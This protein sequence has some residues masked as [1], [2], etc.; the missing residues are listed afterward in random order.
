[1]LTKKTVASSLSSRSQISDFKSAYFKR[2]LNFPIFL[3]MRKKIANIQ[4]PYF[5]NFKYVPPI[6]MT[7]LFYSVLSLSLQITVSFITRPGKKWIQDNLWYI[8]TLSLLAYNNLV[9]VFETF[10]GYS[11][12]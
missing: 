9:S 5:R 3:K 4:D 12:F 7:V 6:L 11:A 2:R 8:V 1:M 10:K